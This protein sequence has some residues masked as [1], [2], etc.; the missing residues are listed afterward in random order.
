MLNPN[1]TIRTH[2][3]VHDVTIHGRA[4]R[5]DDA[6]LAAARCP[7]CTPSRVFDLRRELTA[8]A[9]RLDALDA[10]DHAQSGTLYQLL[11][12]EDAAHFAR[13]AA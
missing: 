9:F 13:R 1:Q 3:H 5:P 12:V 11:T 4:R 8:L 10:L 2:R 6:A 7:I